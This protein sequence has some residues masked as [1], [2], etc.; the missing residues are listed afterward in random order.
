MITLKKRKEK[1]DRTAGAQ[2]QTKAYPHRLV[3][4]SP[5]ELTFDKSNGGGLVQSPVCDLD[6]DRGPDGRDRGDTSATGGGIA[7]VSTLYALIGPDE[8]STSG[9]DSGGGAG[10]RF[11][12][13]GCETAS[14]RGQSPSGG[15]VGGMSCVRAGS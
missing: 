10:C 13:L 15:G 3:V 5:N 9:G 11:S 14:A 7:G 8:Y 4:L 12:R 6:R 2:H 1:K